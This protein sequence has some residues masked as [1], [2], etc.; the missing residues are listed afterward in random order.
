MLKPSKAEFEIAAKKTELKRINYIQGK[1]Q[2]QDLGPGLGNQFHEGE[3]TV[4]AFV[5]EQNRQG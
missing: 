5:E 2:W 1:P 4:A 3:V